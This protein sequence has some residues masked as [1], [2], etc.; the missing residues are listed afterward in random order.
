MPS[1]TGNR[2]VRAVA[3]TMWERDKLQ[4]RVIENLLAAVAPA[5]KRTRRTRPT[6]KPRR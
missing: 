2:I 6:R 1:R 4:M 5:K 3:D